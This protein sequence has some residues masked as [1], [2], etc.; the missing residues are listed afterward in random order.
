MQS[1]AIILAGGEGTRF[2]STLSK[3]FFMIKEKPLISY[4][5]RAFQR[6]PYIDEIVVVGSLTSLKE[7]KTLVQKEGFDKVHHV[8]MGGNTRLESSYLGVNLYN[9]NQE[10]KI[11]IHDGARPLV[12]QK[13]IKDCVDSLDYYQASSLAIPTSDTIFESYNKKIKSIPDRTFFY[14]AQTPQ[15]FLLSILKK[16]YN[17]YTKDVYKDVYKC[18]S[19]NCSL[20]RKYIPEVEIKI[21]EGDRK[22]IKLT[23]PIDA[24]YIKLLLKEDGAKKCK[25]KRKKIKSGT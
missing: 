23:F 11:L 6:S 9:D 13:M 15:S 5:V 16:A 24:G 4:T 1:V 2:S 21:I 14:L 3:Q 20:I 17:A 10:R 25:T 22:N 12:S 19:D 7:I 18:F 8:I